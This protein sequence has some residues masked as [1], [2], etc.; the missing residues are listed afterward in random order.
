MRVRFLSF[1]LYSL[2]MTIELP[3]EKRRALITM[4]DKFLVTRFCKFRDFA[5]LIGSLMAACPGIECGKL[6]CRSVER[7]WFFALLLADDQAVEGD[8][9]WWKDSLQKGSRSMKSGV[10]IK[11]IFFRCFKNRLGCV[12]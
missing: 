6:Y 4:I 12:L 7:E 10:F 8:L 1:V 5:Q 9:L 2:S 11:K 3:L